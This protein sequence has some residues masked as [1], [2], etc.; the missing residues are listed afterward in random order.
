MGDS[1]VT[2]SI[3]ITEALSA[4]L[5]VIKLCESHTH[6][7]TIWK[8]KGP[9]VGH[10]LVSGLYEFSLII[11]WKKKCEIKHRSLSVDNKCIVLQLSLLLIVN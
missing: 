4:V 7:H 8:L 5:N 3:C 9:S 6:I 2:S 1:V 10:L 11:I